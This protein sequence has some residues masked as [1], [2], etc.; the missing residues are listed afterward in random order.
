MH[1]AGGLTVCVEQYREVSSFRKARASVAV[2]F[3]MFWRCT[4]SVA[5]NLSCVAAMVWHMGTQALFFRRLVHT[6]LA[7]QLHDGT[8]AAMAVMFLHVAQHSPLINDGYSLVAH[9]RWVATHA[10]TCAGV[11]NDDGRTHEGQQKPGMTTGCSEGKHGA[12]LAAQVENADDGHV[13]T[14]PVVTGASLVGGVGGLHDTQQLVVLK[15]GASLVLHDGSVG[16]MLVWQLAL[17]AD[18]AQFKPVGGGGPGTHVE[19]HVVVLRVG[20]VPCGQVGKPVVVHA[21]TMAAVQLPASPLDVTHDGQL[22]VESIAGMTPAA[23]WPTA[24]SAV[25]LH[26]MVL[27]L[28]MHVGQHGL[29]ENGSTPRAHRGNAPVGHAPMAEASHNLQLIQQLVALNLGLALFLQYGKVPHAGLA[30]GLG[31]ASPDCAGQA[32]YGFNGAGVGGNVGITGPP[33]VKPT[34][35]PPPPLPPVLPVLPPPPPPP[36]LPGVPLVAPTGTGA[37]TPARETN[38]EE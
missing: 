25:A 6:W 19:Q 8:L 9:A 22:V 18:D 37:A 36:P 35:P 4:G 12:S 26:V 17:T 31:T 30:K 7:L 15:A 33:Q 11:H 23:H 3:A 38:N 20:V 27:V 2:K 13:A 34:Q 14:P 32:L 21:K 10:V 16:K 5:L 29:L 1:V 28:M 24:A